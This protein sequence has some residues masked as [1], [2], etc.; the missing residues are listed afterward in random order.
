M[1]LEYKLKN[2]MLNLLNTLLDKDIDEET[3]K[4]RLFSEPLLFGIIEHSG[5]E[6][7]N[8]RI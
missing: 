1:K 4:Q 3:K 8:I 2:N 7:K 5:F 6:S